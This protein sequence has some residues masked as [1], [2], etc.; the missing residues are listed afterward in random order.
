MWRRGKVANDEPKW[1]QGSSSPGVMQWDWLSA[2][3]WGGRGLC[4][5]LSRGG[6]S[7]KVAF[8]RK[9]VMIVCSM[10]WGATVGRKGE[11]D[12]NICDEGNL[13]WPGTAESA[14]VWGKLVWAIK[15][16][17]L[18][19]R[20]AF[21]QLDN[22]NKVLP[23]DSKLEF[24]TGC[25][26]CINFQ[27]QLRLLWEHN[28]LVSTVPTTPY[29]F[30]LTGP[31]LCTTSALSPVKVAIFMLAWFAVAHFRLQVLRDRKLLD[32]LPSSRMWRAN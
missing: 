28:A 30:T 4:C 25:G 21:N 1:G 15:W 16:L 5:L 32:L 18:N 12:T 8:W 26:L 27:L 20:S 29:C 31:S 9:D 14:V 3:W 11:G 19:P 6:T 7:I 10:A 17:H 22:I 24:Q 23:W 13:L 2:A